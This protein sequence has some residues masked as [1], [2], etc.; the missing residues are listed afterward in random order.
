MAW[1]TGLLDGDLE[2]LRTAGVGAAVGGAA[3]VVQY[4]GDVGRALLV[5]SRSEAQGSRVPLT[6]AGDGGPGGK[7]PWVGVADHLEG[8]DLIAL[9]VG[10]GGDAY[11]KPADRVRRLSRPHLDLTD[12]NAEPR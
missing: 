5:S 11:R 12:P 7:E 9:V 10:A 2:G 3:V 1:I 8:E 4:D 6:I